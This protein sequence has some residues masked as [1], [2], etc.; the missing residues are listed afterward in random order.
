MCPVGHRAVMFVPIVGVLAA[1]P[2]VSGAQEPPSVSAVRA[3]A[4]ETAGLVVDGDLNDPAWRLARPVA[5][6]RQREPLTGAAATER[7]DVLA[8]FDDRTLYIGI[9]AWDR[10]PD[11]VIARILERDRLMSFDFNG[12]A[13]AGDDAVA[14]LL[15]TFHD[16]RNAVVFATNPNGAQFD[17]LVT[18]EG[19]EFNV[20]WRGLWDVAARRTADGWSAEFAI[21]FR[22]LR[23]DGNAGSGTWGFNVYR[24]IRRKNEEVLLSA[25][26]RDGEGFTRVGRAGHLEGLTGLPRPA[27]NLEVKPFA[28]SGA[29][30]DAFASGGR[31]TGRMDVGL[32][33]KYEVRPGLVL[34]VTANPDFAHVEVDDQQVNLTR[35][36]LFFPE[37]RDFFLE[38]AGVFDF[39]WRTVAEPPPFLMFFSRRIGIDGR[40]GEVPVL[41]GAR[42]SGRIGGQTVGVMTAVSDDAL[43][44]TRHAHSVG[45]IKRDVGTS[46]YVGAMVTDRRGGMRT[47]SAAGVDGAMW[48]SD[49]L[50]VDGFVARTFD[51]TAGA[52]GAFS[53]AA[54]YHADEVGLTLRHLTVGAE[55]RAGS[56]FVTRTDVRRSDAFLRLTARPGILGLRRFDVHVKAQ[57]IV[58]MRGRLQDWVVGPSF[59][60]QWPSGEHLNVYVLRGFTRVPGAFDLPGNVPVRS[61]HYDMWQVG[62]IAGTSAHRP[63][64]LSVSGWVQ[65]I[66]DGVLRSVSARVSAAVG[67]HAKL[68][69]AHAHHEAELPAGAFAGELVSLELGYAFSTRVFASGL[70]QYNG[71]DDSF[72]TNFR[73]NVIH[74]PGSDLFVVF[75]ETR[76]VPDDAFRLATRTAV[77]KLTYVTRF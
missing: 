46:G 40:G 27:W 5:G 64:T 24:V 48:L 42:L 22:T 25:W 41:G 58:D 15:D 53:V 19:R 67:R 55:T 6:F 17:A 10:D 4:R 43:D 60:P 61:G 59:Q 35:F 63:V 52:S 8:L 57:H 16:H 69:A 12:L 29:T 50:R 14:I 76:G 31:T 70:I 56:G 75:N 44:G 32:D 45:R 74:R 72:D 39:G 13:F 20:D 30:H 21:P 23:Y 68:T 3:S 49:R 77:A 62:W 47:N 36:D 71:L 28:L 51:D 18:D 33:V 2:A 73:L 26:S 66:Y 37:K 9:R 11:A 54:D 38:N 34:D 1:A 7:T 65:H